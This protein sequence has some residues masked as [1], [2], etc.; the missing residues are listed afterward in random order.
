MSNNRYTIAYEYQDVLYLNITNRCPNLCIFCIKSKWNMNY[1]GYNLKL[2]EEPSVVEIINQIE[3]MF[4]KKKYREIV[5]CGYGEPL[6]RWNV[7]K[8][9][10]LRIKKGESLNLPKDIKI[11][12]NTNGLGNL[13]NNRDITP[14]MVGIID[15]LH[16]SLNTVNKNRW[17]EIMRPFNDYKDGAF[18]SVI[19]FIKKAKMWVKEVVITA[20]D[21]D[22]IDT[23]DVEV[24]AKELGVGFRLRP[25]L[26]KYEET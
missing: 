9:V 25:Y 4:S 1:R 24:F 12:I 26:D 19:D 10:A 18:E 16:I 14:E 13:I 6:M 3:I 15:S 22:G 7:V 5:F 8:D 17:Y 21:I 20:V 2:E 11:R 23:K